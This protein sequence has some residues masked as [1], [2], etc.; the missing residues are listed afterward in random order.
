[1]A[2]QHRIEL[3]RAVMCAAIDLMIQIKRRSIRIQTYAKRRRLMIDQKIKKV[4]LI[5]RRA[6][7]G[8]R[9]SAKNAAL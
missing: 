4:T 6:L 8:F 1:M 2:V 7:R 9:A 3:A 5:L